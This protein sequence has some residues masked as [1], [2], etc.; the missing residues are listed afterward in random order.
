MLTRG[1]TLDRRDVQTG[2]RVTIDE[3]FAEFPASADA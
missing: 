2:F 3:V 1:D